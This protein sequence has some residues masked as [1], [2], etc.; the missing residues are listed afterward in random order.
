MHDNGG[1]RQIVWTEIVLSLIDHNLAARKSVEL[2]IDFRGIAIP[3]FLLQETVFL[4]LLSIGAHGGEGLDDTLEPNGQHLGGYLL[5]NL[6]L[7]ASGI[8]LYNRDDIT[9]DFGVGNGVIQKKNLKLT[10]VYPPP[11]EVS[12]NFTT[13]LEKG[14]F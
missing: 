6:G 13:R 9:V 2:C 5:A 3:V 1:R 10:I 8:L 7:S 14:T 4:F 11:P 12:D